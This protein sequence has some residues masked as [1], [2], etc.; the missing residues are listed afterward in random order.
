MATLSRFIRTAVALLAVL[1][2]ASSPGIALAQSS[3]YPA[4]PTGTPAG[5]PTP[6]TTPT[7]TTGASYTPGEIGTGSTKALSAITSMFNA[8]IATAVNASQLVKPEADKLAGGL[9]VIT[10]V[11]AFARY[12]ATPHPT[13]AWLGVF[14]DLAMLGIFASIYV[15]YAT[16]APGFYGWFGTLANDI[17]G[18]NVANGANGLGAAASELY[19][20]I[21]KSLNGAAWYEYIKALLMIGP[22]LIAYVVLMI[23]SLVFAYFSNIGQLQAAAGIV[24]GQIAVALGFSPFTRGYF[25]SWLDYMVSASMY[26][27]V[28]AIL[29]KLVSGSLLTAIAAGSKVGLSTPEG[30]TYVMDLSIFVFLLSFEIPKI[31][32]MFGGGANA[33]GSALGKVAKIVSGGVL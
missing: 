9:A 19:D 1:F 21:V 12:A 17:A 23:T 2:V 7:G 14:E 15:G 25:K 3:G 22:L 5:T 24:M 6:P 30:A 13:M 10:L 4:L 33:S 11:L 8:V 20:A 18:A 32:G 28:A 16:F 29:M 31:A 27:V 26:T